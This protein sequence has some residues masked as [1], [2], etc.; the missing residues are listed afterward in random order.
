MAKRRPAV[1]DT[2]K[3]VSVRISDP[4]IVDRLN[5][6]LERVWS[7]QRFA[8][9]S[10]FLRELMGVEDAGLISPDDRAF[11]TGRKLLDQNYRDS[12]F[13]ELWLVYE[14]ADEKK[15]EMV[16][17]I[18][19]SVLQEIREQ[20]SQAGGNSSSLIVNGS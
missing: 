1:F 18:I 2:K 4:E 9:K 15:R 20:L 14:K 8:D 17:R 12:P 16:G 13:Y 5:T 10:A 19:K 7:D 3:S 11:I 6:V